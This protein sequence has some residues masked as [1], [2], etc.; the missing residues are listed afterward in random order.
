MTNQN[1]N[2]PYSAIENN[3]SN[4]DLFCDCSCGKAK[5]PLVSKYLIYP[6]SSNQT[7]NTIILENRESIFNILNQR[8]YD[9]NIMEVGVLAGDFAEKMLKS[10]PIDNLYLIDPFNIDDPM[11]VDGKQRF[12]KEN[13]FYFIQ[14]KFQ[15]KKNVHTI[16]N[17]SK[18]FM[19]QFLQTAKN[20]IDLRFDFIYIDS[21]HKF[22]N[23]YNEILYAS[24]ILKN[25]GIIGIDDFT[26]YSDYPIEPCEVM[27]AVTTFLKHNKNWE[28]S[29]YSFNDAGIPNI[30]LS[31]I[32]D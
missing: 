7:K 5:N 25:D 10:M 14:K 29:Y 31:K 26:L 2:N 12:T 9:L 19:P 6:I 3:L 8:N 21:D 30:Y 13:H 22:L 28:V 1:N 11:L 18:N 24:Q 16:S 4:N 27:Q 20:G 32:N 23:T 17:F 15:S